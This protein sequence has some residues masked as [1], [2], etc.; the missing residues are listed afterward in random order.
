M[1]TPLARYFEIVDSAVSD[2]SVLDSLRDLFAEEFVLLHCGEFVQGRERAIAFHQRKAAKRKEIKHSLTVSAQTDESVT[3]QWSEAGLDLQGDEFSANGEVTAVLDG[4]GRISLLSLTLTGSSERARLITAKHLQV[5]TVRDP[6]ERAKAIEETYAENIT[7][8]EP[9]PDNIYVGR[10][11]LNDYIGV[12]QQQAPPVSIEVESY[13]KNR[14]FVHF[15]WD[16][17]FP[18]EKTA[19]GWE[20]IET[21]GD[22]IEKIVIFSPDH[23]VVTEKLQ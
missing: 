2:H 19:V 8:M 12:V 10:A 9:E 11:A 17:V 6:I 4:V 20:V 15:R 13:Y 5:W 7:F 16:A 14:E 3:A 18:P 23:E 21:T 22:L 1:T